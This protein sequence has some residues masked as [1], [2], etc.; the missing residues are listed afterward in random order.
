MPSEALL[1]TKAEYSFHSASYSPTGNNA[2]SSGSP[3]TVDLTMAS[4]ADG[5]AIN[6]DQVDLGAT[7]AT[8]YFLLGAIEWFAAVAAGGRVDFYWS[9]SSHSTVTIGNAGRTDGVDGAYTG[10]GG[11]TVAESVKQMIRIGA[12]IT[13]DLV[14]VQIATIGSFFAPT[15]YGQLVVVNS[16][17]TTICGTDDI[18]SAILMTALVVEGQ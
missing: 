6:S 12:F 5:S 4:L 9:A 2:L 3:T 17:G 13:T 18:E 1:K 14:G 16:S 15:Q 8:E 10:D 11:G 7:R